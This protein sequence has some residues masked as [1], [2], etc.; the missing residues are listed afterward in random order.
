MVPNMILRARARAALKPLMP[1]VILCALIANLPSLAAQTVGLLTGAD[2]MSYLLGSAPTDAELMALLS[3]NEAIFAAFEGY[4]NPSRMASLAL[5]GLSFLVSPVL[6][7]GLNHSILLL[8]RNQEITVGSVF[9][10]MG[11]LLKSIALNIVTLIKIL[12]WSIPGGAVMV[13]GG[14]IAILTQQ[15]W[16]LALYFVGLVLMMVQM[17]RA[18]LHYAMSTVFLADD[19]T[20]GVF[21]SLKKS[22]R[23]MR[24]RKMALLSLTLSVYVWM[25]AVSLLEGLVAGLFGQVIA[26]TVYM[27]LQLIISVYMNACH[28]A[29]Y[30]FYRQAEP[31]EA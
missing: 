10:R 23:M 2:P 25:I 3:S 12:L 14:V 17:I 19:P 18:M 27:A 20:M 11:A 13:L 7:L 15:T 6:M 4:M 22:I 24:T 30:E 29:F 16:L 1:V 26:S 31:Q 8:L 9:G 5:Y 28:C 21:A